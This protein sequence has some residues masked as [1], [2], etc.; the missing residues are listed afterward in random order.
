MPLRVSI[1]VEMGYPDVV[2][3]QFQETF[4]GKGQVIYESITVPTQPLLNLDGKA[5]TVKS[6][7]E[8]L[9]ENL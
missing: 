1:A 3:V 2:K 4:A 9:K 8:F 6:G 7:P 5:L